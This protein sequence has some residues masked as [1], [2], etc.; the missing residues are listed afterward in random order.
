M[1]STMSETAVCHLRIRRS[2][3]EP[4]LRHLLARGEIYAVGTIRRQG[5]LG[6][7]MLLVDE[8]DI[9]ATIPSGLQRP[10]LDDWFVLA[11]ASDAAESIDQIVGILQ[12]RPSQ[13]LVVLLLERSAPERCRLAQVSQGQITSID[14]CEVIGSGMLKL[15]S[16]PIATHPLDERR[17]SRTRGALG[18][19]LHDRLREATVTVVGVG[20]NG[21]QMCFLLAGLGIGRLRLVD[22]DVLQ[23]ENLDAMPGLTVNDIGLSKAESLAVRLTAFQPDLSVTYVEK[24]VTSREAIQLLHR[25]CDLL[26][27]TVDNDAARLAVSLLANQ[28]LTPHLDIGTLVRRDEN[29]TS[30]Y[31]DIRMLLPGMCVACVGGLADAEAAFY[32]LNAPDGSLK[33]G[34]PVD[35]SDQRSGSLVHVNTMACSMGIELWLR[36]LRGEAGAYWQRV[37]WKAGHLLDVA[38]TEVTGNV[39]C[40]Q[41]QP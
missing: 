30:L 32:E 36:L 19:E 4:T 11:M 12:P 27:S 6:D 35:W 28:T 2:A 1:S 18:D 23:P 16:R 24:S 38:G 29:D 21:S 40:Q 31:A 39:A 3:W 15:R 37:T 26:I 14:V 34:E 8:L 22:A 7:V 25:P 13:T 10:P 20:R 5:A 33:R 9:P 41:C 17:S